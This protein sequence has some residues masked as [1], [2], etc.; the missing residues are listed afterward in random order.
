MNQEMQWPLEAKNKP[1]FIAI[2]K[3]RLQSHNYK[4]MNFDN[5]WNELEM[6]YPIKPPG[7]NTACCFKNTKV[8][9]N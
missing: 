3:I 8:G 1:Q 5:N 4:K 2:K 7:R 6:D 9:Q